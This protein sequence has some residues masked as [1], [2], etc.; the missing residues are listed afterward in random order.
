[1]TRI[2]EI[3]ERFLGADGEYA[4]TPRGEVP[5]EAAARIDIEL[6]DRDE[7]RERS[8]RGFGWSNRF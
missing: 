6:S 5:C 8:A 7:A 4:E 1:M 3:F 2:I